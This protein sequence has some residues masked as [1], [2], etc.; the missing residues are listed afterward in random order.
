[1]FLHHTHLYIFSLSLSLSLYIYIY[2]YN[3]VYTY[4]IRTWFILST[5]M[6]AVTPS[7]HWIYSWSLL[8]CTRNTTMTKRAFNMKSVNTARSLRSFSFFESSCSFC[9]HGQFTFLNKR[10]TSTLCVIVCRKVRIRDVMHFIMAE[11]DRNLM[12]PV[13]AGSLLEV[14]SGVMPSEEG[15]S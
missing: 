6:F 14:W 5:V 4:N 11:T 7:G 8:S 13:R 12:A 9:K 15:L 10:L 1:V 3:F 2:I